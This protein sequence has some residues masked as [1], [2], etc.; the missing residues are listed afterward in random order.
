ML[1][2]RDLFVDWKEWQHPL[3]TPETPPWVI[4]LC[5]KTSHR[6]SIHSRQIMLVLMEGVLVDVKS[7]SFRF[8]QLVILPRT[9]Q[10]KAIHWADQLPVWMSLN[11]RDQPCPT[12]FPIMRQ[13]HPQPVDES[14]T[15]K[16]MNTFYWDSSTWTKRGSFFTLHKMPTR[17]RMSLKVCIL[18][19]VI[20]NIN[21]RY[22]A[23]GDCGAPHV[24]TIP[25]S[26][27]PF[28]FAF[29]AHWERIYASICDVKQEYIR[30]RP[31]SVHPCVCFAPLQS[32]PKTLQPIPHQIAE[33]M[34]FGLI[35]SHGYSAIC[36]VP[37]ANVNDS[38]P[39][40]NI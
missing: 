15:K 14:W 38:G 34:R 4:K 16:Q 18:Y 12:L 24:V 28:R 35:K 6:H 22:Q 37:R 1:K 26:R 13:K 20:A 29:K 39:Q 3:D 36:N 8:A 23:A 33:A 7:L 5:P 17:G 21:L 32:W 11:R 2:E 25:V 31:S 30:T 40:S 9:P 27:S 19:H 10:E